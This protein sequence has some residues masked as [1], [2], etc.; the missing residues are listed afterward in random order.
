M[1]MSKTLTSLIAVCLVAGCG[2]NLPFWPF[3]KTQAPTAT[4][5]ATAQPEAA[6]TPP[7]STKADAPAVKTEA[8][9]APPTK[10]PG[11]G[12][13]N[14]SDGIKA[15][16]AGD[17]KSASKALRSALTLG[18]TEKV[19]EVSAHKFLAFTNCLTSREQLC[20]AEFSKAL[21]IYPGFDL[22]P[23]EAANPQIGPVFRSIKAGK[24]T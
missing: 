2:I 13:Q 17:Y 8:L 23:S 20:R 9:T 11:R 15:Y 1:T 24:K 12:Q 14:L 18:L 19:D 6:V 3:N 4:A 10:G 7:P 16:Y 5:P 22:D 21:D